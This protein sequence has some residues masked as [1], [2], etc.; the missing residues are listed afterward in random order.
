MDNKND[1]IV[2]NVKESEKKSKG[3]FN[4]IIPKILSVVFAFSLWFYVVS[5]ESPINEKTFEL[6]KI[7]II[8]NG[9]SGLS[10][11]SVDGDTV[12]I[13]VKGKRSDL[14]QLSA[15]DFS[16]VAD[17]SKITE[18]GE[19]TVSVKINVPSG[20]TLT[21]QSRKAITVSLDVKKQSEIDIEVVADYT[22]ASDCDPLD[23]S[24]FI[25]S[26]ETLT[27]SGPEKI[28]NNIAGARIKY[29]HK[30]PVLDSEV[31]GGSN[32]IELYTKDGG[33][34]SD[35]QRK[36]VSLST[37]Y[38]N[39][40]IPVYMTKTVKLTANFGSGYLNN[41]NCNINISPSSVELTGPAQILRTIDTWPVYTVNE[42]TVPNETVSLSIIGKLPEGCELK[43]P[44][45]EIA[46]ITFQLLDTESKTLKVSNI[47]INNP[48]KL[49]YKLAEEKLDIKIEGV[50]S[51]IKSISASDVT[52]KAD[53]TNV[54]NGKAPISVEFS[55]KFSNSV[56]V[57][58]TYSIKVE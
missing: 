51:A 50:S 1:K 29:V 35:S 33:V 10:P 40:T 47:T 30:E 14:N 20:A 12:D 38:V 34:L 57:I 5:V 32:D 16:A 2:T 49:N 54:K 36:K 8:Q 44:E 41:E 45:D 48:D 21:K 11:F 13:T 27:V 28:I 52:L 19:H 4:D 18:A 22:L 58:G 42:G 31:S 46:E 53:F 23:E 9:N 3:R 17:V 55:S 39:Y 43:N 24:R 25:T 26:P 6:I 56:I 15:D 37:D 7:E